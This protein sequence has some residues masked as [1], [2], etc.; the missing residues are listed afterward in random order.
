MSWDCKR[1]KRGHTFSSSARSHLLLSEP[2][3]LRKLLLQRHL[4]L[5][6]GRSGHL[7]LG[8]LIL[9][10]IPVILPS[11]IVSRYQAR[12]CRRAESCDNTHIIIVLVLSVPFALRRTRRGRD[13]RS[14]RG[15][16]GRGV[17]RA[18]GDG[19]VLDICVESASGLMLA[20]SFQQGFGRLTAYATHPSRRPLCVLC[21][22]GR[23]VKVG[24]EG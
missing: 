5:G 15:E 8:L 2:L 3:L 13:S 19:S 23:S 17:G 10:L 24:R 11:G 20:S 6:R 9:A 16:R 4:L 1:G 14:G 12:R 7:G 21:C 22:G 18:R